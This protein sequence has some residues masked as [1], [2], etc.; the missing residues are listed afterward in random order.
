MVSFYTFRSNALAGRTLTENPT[1]SRDEIEEWI[2][3]EYN[4]QRAK[5]EALADASVVLKR[6]GFQSGRIK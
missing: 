5:E 3:Q 1:M 6:L 4:R 2:R